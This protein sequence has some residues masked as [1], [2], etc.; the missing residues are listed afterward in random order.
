MNF[1][2]VLIFS[3]SCVIAKIGSFLY[4]PVAL[5]YA[6]QSNALHMNDRLQITHQECLNVTC[7]KVVRTILK[8]DVKTLEIDMKMVRKEIENN[9][10]ILVVDSEPNSLI[11]YENLLHVCDHSVHPDV[12]SL[13]GN[14]ANA[15]KSMLKWIEDS[16]WQLTD[17]PFKVSG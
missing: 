4:L 15:W 17:P 6:K 7:N 5:K 8:T 12:Q 3:S 13:K 11:F 1:K 9:R 10:S 2:K 14:Y 16:G